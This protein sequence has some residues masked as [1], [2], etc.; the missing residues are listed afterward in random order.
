[1]YKNKLREMGFN[2]KESDNTFDNF[3]KENLVEKI[4][5]EKEFVI[6]FHNL[7]NK[8]HFKNDNDIVKF[9]LADVLVKRFR[10]LKYDFKF[11]IEIGEV[12]EFAGLNFEFNDLDQSDFLVYRITI[13]KK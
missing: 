5:I 13:L 4:D 11:T 6:L 12:D 9:I 10:T 3:I 1:M 2:L 8:D 7:V